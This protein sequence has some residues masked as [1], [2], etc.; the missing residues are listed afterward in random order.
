MLSNLISIEGCP[1]FNNK[2]DSFSYELLIIMQRLNTSFPYTHPYLTHPYHI[3]N[4]FP[5]CPLPLFLFPHPLSLIPSSRFLFPI[6]IP[7]FL[8]PIRLQTPLNTKNSPSRRSL[9]DPT[10][11]IHVSCC[12]L[13]QRNSQRGN[14]ETSF[15]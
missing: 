3:I 9:T 10:D 1:P 11:P 2:N 14:G 8:I 12:S 6:P 13:L 5:L 15:V 7:L 4:P